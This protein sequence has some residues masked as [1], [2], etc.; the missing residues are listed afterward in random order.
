[1]K[2]EHEVHSDSSR[3]ITSESLSGLEP[4]FRPADA[5]RKYFLRSNRIVCCIEAMQTEG[6]GKQQ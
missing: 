4:F 6:A 5:G 1:M 3:A 2:N